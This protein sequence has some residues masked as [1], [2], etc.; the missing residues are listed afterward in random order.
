MLPAI[1]EFAKRVK[2]QHSIPT[3]IVLEVGSYNV[4][5]SPREVFQ[6]EAKSY[7]GVDMDEGPDVD[8]VVNG[9]ELTTAFDHTFDTVICMET[10]EHV[11]NP[12]KVVEQL[13]AVLSPGGHLW[14]ST[15]T[16]GFP[17]HRFPIDC[18]RFGED[19]YRLVFF[20]DMELIALEEVK[21]SEN[22]PVI[23]AVGR[24]K[25]D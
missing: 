5:G 11:K 8:R 23:V 18:Y 21:D 16:F 10:L 20:A 9:E 25:L 2:D 3:G 14:I 22:N 24:K 6:A 4:N 17:L 15:P 12:W 7:I 13:K 19:A 1:L